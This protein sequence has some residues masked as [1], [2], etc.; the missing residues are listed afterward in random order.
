[1]ETLL[2][3]IALFTFQAL[4]T[5]S[6]EPAALPPLYGIRREALL[7]QFTLQKCNLQV[8]ASSAA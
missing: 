2:W 1:M 8:T 3:M 7:Y 6:V 5:L 4:Y